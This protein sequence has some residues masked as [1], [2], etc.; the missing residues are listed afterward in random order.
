M[1]FK[2]AESSRVIQDL[3]RTPSTT[4]P[5]EILT[6]DLSYGTFEVQESQRCFFESGC[7]FEK[8]KMAAGG[9]FENLKS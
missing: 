4:H 3:S 6:L 9:H 1:D 8:S 7:E 5:A 2:N